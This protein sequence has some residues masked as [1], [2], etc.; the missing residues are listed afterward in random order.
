M[1]PIRW[2]CFAALAAFALLPSAATAS[3]S[4]EIWTDRGT[5]GV[6]EPGQAIE[7]HARSSDDSHLLVYE[8]DAEG[9]IH[10]LFPLRGS[11]DLIEG[12]R[13]L[14]IPDPNASEQL[15]VQG[16]VGQGYI[17]A[18]ATLEPLR[19]LPW[20]L[21]PYDPQGEG[22]GFIGAPDPADEEEGITSEGRVVGDPFVAMER[23]RRRIVTDPDNQE[24]FSSAYTT[25]Y[26]HQEVR[27][28]RYVC[29]DCHRSDHWAWWDGFDPYYTTCSVFDFRVNWA[30]AW[31]RP[32]WYGYV[33]YYVYV[34]RP[35]CPPY[36]QPWAGYC[37]SSWD[38]WNRWNTLWGAHLRRYKSPPPPGYVPPDDR[39]WKDRQPAGPPPGFLATAAART[40]AARRMPSTPNPQIEVVPRTDW[41][42]G[43]EPT[44]RRAVRSP[45]S[46]PPRDE[47]VAEGRTVERP[48]VGVRPDS[49]PGRGAR[50]ESDPGRSVRPDPGR[51]RTVT[52]GGR[53]VRGLD[54]GGR[55]APAPRGGSDRTPR[56]GRRFED[57]YWRSPGRGGSAPGSPDGAPGEAW[58]GTGPSSGWGGP[59]VTARRE[60]R[61]QAPQGG[62]RADAPVFAPRG[63]GGRLQYSPPSGG[64]AP[65]GMRGGGAPAVGGRGAVGG[66]V[67]PGGMAVRGTRP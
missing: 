56:A 63:G 15:V 10:V 8:I 19:D 60:Y 55:L 14:P 13:T 25:Y 59:P 37:Y 38:G 36:Y 28:P 49:G 45:V 66:A 44:D 5:D 12:G 51:G 58:S 42:P 30:W 34:V 16:P 47:G 50:P 67:N 24:G 17:V 20:Y 6:Y 29:L 32:Y 4:V 46:G 62:P 41:R 53:Y 64:G 43:G 23:I 57:P 40:R 7:L 22:V 65:G 31:G 52:G 33:P 18:V 54:A 3:L 1:S 9:Y 21:R 61:P 48:Q 39:R 2:S 35:Y 11:P 26:V 27:Y